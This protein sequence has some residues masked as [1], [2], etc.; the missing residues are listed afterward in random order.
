MMAKIYRHFGLTS[1][2]LWK[3]ARAPVLPLPRQGGAFSADEM[4]LK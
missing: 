1:G 4:V 2:C 3:M